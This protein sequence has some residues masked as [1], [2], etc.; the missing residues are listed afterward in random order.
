[1]QEFSYLLRRISCLVADR[2]H[3]PVYIDGTALSKDMPKSVPHLLKGHLDWYPLAVLQNPDILSRTIYLLIDNADDLTDAQMRTLR[4][5]AHRCVIIVAAVRAPRTIDGY[6]NYYIA[7]IEDGAVHNF[8]RSLDLDQA[9][10]SPLT[11]RAMHYIQRT[12]GISGLPSNPFTVSVMLSECQIARR[13][14]TTPTMGRLIER[15][16]EDQLGSH[17]DTMRADFETKLQFLTH[18]GGAHQTEI[19]TVAFRKRLAR[20][21]ATHGHAHDISDF[22]EDIF[23]SGLIE[24]DEIKGVVR[25][26]HPIFR[27]FFWVRNLVREK[28]YKVIARALL[29]GATPSIAAIAG[30]QMGNAHAVLG[31]LL[32]VIRRQD[33]MNA[34]KSRRR[35][36]SATL[37]DQLL[38]SDSDEDLM[39]KGIEEHALGQSDITEGG[40]KASEQPAGD[41]DVSID[42]DITKLISVY[43]ARILEEKHYVVGNVGALLVNARNLSRSDKE[44]A[45]LCVLRSNARMARHLEGVLRMITKRKPN[46]LMTQAVGTFSELVI[47]D[48][49]IGDAFLSEIFRSV[50]DGVKTDAEKIAVTDLLVACGSAAPGAYIKALSPKQ[51][52]PDIVAVYIR[53]VHLYY[54]RFHKEKDKAELRDAMKSVRRLAKGLS[55][56]P[57]T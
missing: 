34:V 53:L 13:R 3:L 44:T 57:V 11:D 55:L 9:V 25:W 30:S 38:P 1:V 12:I 24:R 39:L 26:T 36:S 6:I 22:Q 46:P 49:M 31:D 21:L 35:E 16:V 33:W 10:A 42:E 28:K 23:E 41:T 2:G 54:F 37:S 52:F 50:L 20:F 51:Q 56:P 8:V 4:E 40:A 45:A 5:S 29:K 48:L 47:N 27:D 17:L 15:F 14:L 43:T 32:S 18:F 7:G 19:L